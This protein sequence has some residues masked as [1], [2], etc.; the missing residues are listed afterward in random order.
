MHPISIVFSHVDRD[1]VGR[2]RTRAR[3]HTYENGRI[4]A[5]VLSIQHYP[6]PTFY[7]ELLKTAEKRISTINFEIAIYDTRHDQV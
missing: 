3:Q 1:I 2:F 6:D 5:Y 7:E 4:V